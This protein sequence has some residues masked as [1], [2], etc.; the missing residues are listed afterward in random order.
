MNYHNIYACDRLINPQ[1]PKPATP[2]EI[3]LL[4]IKEA[5][6]GAK[7]NIKILNPLDH[8]TCLANCT[9]TSCSRNCIT[10]DVS[11]SSERKSLN[12][13]FQWMCNGLHEHIVP[14]F[15]YCMPPR[16]LT[17][18]AHTV[19]SA[20]DSTSWWCLCLP[21]GSQ[22]H[23]VSTKTASPTQTR[24]LWTE[25][26]VERDKMQTQQQKNNKTKPRLDYGL[27]IL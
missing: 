21:Q 25:E 5:S 26:R 4:V 13:K 20:V 19:I 17:E 11:Q 27:W 12:N 8:I 1:I 7:N 10:P 18:C 6:S 16:I 3:S 2:R 9:L 22:K 24:A 14:L 15:I 23:A